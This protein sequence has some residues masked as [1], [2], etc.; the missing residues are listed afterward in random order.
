MSCKSLISV[1]VCACVYDLLDI[2]FY[3]FFIFINIHSRSDSTEKSGGSWW[4]VSGG[5][6][7]GVTYER[8]VS[9]SER[10]EK[11]TLD[12]ARALSLDLDKPQPALPGHGDTLAYSDGGHTHPGV[13]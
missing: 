7:G 4:D 8:S 1:C 2:F 6:V 5:V 13:R 11:R 12:N 3:I 10:G 9:E